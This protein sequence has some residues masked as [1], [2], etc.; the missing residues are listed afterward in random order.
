MIG[1][2]NGILLD[3]EGPLLTIE[4]GGV[5][6]EVLISEATAS[7]MP[8]VGEPIFIYIRQIVREDGISLYGFLRPH[9]RR[10]FD[11]LR[12]VQGCGPKVAL[13][14]LATLSPQAIAHA[15]LDSRPKELT[16][17]PGVGPKLGE[18]IA[19]ELKSKLGDEWALLRPEARMPIGDRMGTSTNEELIDALQSLGYRRN[20]AEAAAS[21]S[22]SIGVGS[23]QLQERLRI[24]LA[25][26]R[27]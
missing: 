24:A 7:E 19:L 6:Y 16:K 8:T 5:G 26:L 14:L 1:S 13:S 21:H 25:F 2:L 9:E 17:A 4:C 23:P 3:K 11:L 22:D 15:I 18:R 27:K 20:E 12:N 10:I